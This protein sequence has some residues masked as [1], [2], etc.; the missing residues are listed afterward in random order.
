MMFFHNISKPPS[1]TVGD[2][3]IPHFYDHEDDSAKMAKEILKRLRFENKTIEVVTTMI[4]FYKLKPEPTHK[5][6]RK[7][8]SKIGAKNFSYFYAVRVGDMMGQ[9]LVFSPQRIRK[10]NH[11]REIA[12][13]IITTKE[14]LRVSS[15]AISSKDILA[16]GIA[17]GK[18]VGV[19]LN[20]L[21]ESVIDEVT[22]NERESLLSAAKDFL[23]KT[24]C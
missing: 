14:C 2:D 24:L 18:Q 1:R 22:F 13:E 20:R 8:L 9:T 3:G 16:L 7:L 19:I 17:E 21:L 12:M 11:I 5:S 4:G 15:L 23:K 6:V 10:I